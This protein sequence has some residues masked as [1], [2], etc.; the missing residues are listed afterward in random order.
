MPYYRRRGSYSRKRY[1][2]YR[3]RGS[4]LS[5]RNLLTRKS[6]TAQALQL[7]AVNRKVNKVM[8]LCKP[9]YKVVHGDHINYDFSNSAFE[10]SHKEY[11]PPAINVGPGDNERVGNKIWRRDTFHINLMYTNNK[12]SS[13]GLN[14]GSVSAGTLRAIL[15]I[16]KIPSA[17]NSTPSPSSVVHGVG[18]ALTNYDYW[19][20]QPLEDNVTERYRVVFDRKIT[21]SID[22]QTKFVKFKTPWYECR[23]NDNTSPADVIQSHLILL[24]CN[25]NASAM[26]DLLHMHGTRKTVFRDA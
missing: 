17:Q 3:R 5:T 7:R 25:M 4:T 15:L 21:V 23:F 2:R 9:E 16:D 12:A 22:D 18:S 6:A 10:V 19:P 20:V 1:S 14:N 11:N 13:S 8:K 26:N 24:S